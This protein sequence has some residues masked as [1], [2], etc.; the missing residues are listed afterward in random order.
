MEFV[1]SALLWY[2]F[3]AVVTHAVYTT[4]NRRNSRRQD[5][6]RALRGQPPFRPDAESERLGRWLRAW[7]AALWPLWWLV[8]AAGLWREH[9]RR[10]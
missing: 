10:R 8:R 3:G 5:R 6:E 4:A 9:R 7:I 2:A 1:L